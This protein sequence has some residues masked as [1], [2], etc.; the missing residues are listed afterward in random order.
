MMNVHAPIEWP[1][2]VKLSVTQFWLLKQSGAFNAYSKSELLEGEM[3]GVPLQ[4][5]DEPESDASVPI[6]LRIEDYRRLHEAG[7]LEMNG[8]TELIDGLLYEV[9]PQYRPHG[10]VK[11]ELAYRIRRCLE[12]LGSP[13][14]VATEQSVAITPYSEPQPDIILTTQPRGPGAIP[15]ASVALLIEISSTTA[16]FDLNEKVRLYASA[17]IQ[18]YW[19]ADVNARI[20]HQM[21]V[22]ARNAYVEGREVS[23]GQ[24]IVAETIERL[25]IDLGGL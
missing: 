1:K 24:R 14:H 9:S 20:V 15:S 17:G 21:W 16:T 6:R 22:P 3:S 8:K 18:E 2:S 23:F 19:V 13:L 11:D 5:D 7:L 4:G 10:F 12:A 25:D